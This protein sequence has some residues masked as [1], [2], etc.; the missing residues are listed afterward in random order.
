[1]ATNN[2]SATFLPEDVKSVL[3]DIENIESKMPFLVNVTSKDKKAR[4]QMGANSFGYVQYGLATAK[5][6]DG[7]LARSFSVEEYQ[8]DS[9]TSVGVLQVYNRLTPLYQ[10]LKD[11]LSLLGQDLMD[12]TNEVYSA[13][14]REAKT[15]G[16]LKSVAEEMGKRYEVSHKEE[17]AE[18]KAQ[19][20]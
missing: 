3:T 1:M 6:N 16:A 12:Q 11:T 13:V 2:I 14:K 15:N 7:I 8:K 17:P 19:T 10:K 4:Q 18:A 9:D 5:N 20:H